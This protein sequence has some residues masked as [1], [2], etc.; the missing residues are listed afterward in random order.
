MITNIEDYKLLKSFHTKLSEGKDVNGVEL[1]TALNN[2]QTVRR[3]RYV[4]CSGCVKDMINFLVLI[5]KKYE[6][7]NNL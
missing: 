6:T 1:A 3:F 4:S 7:E 2:V 5:I